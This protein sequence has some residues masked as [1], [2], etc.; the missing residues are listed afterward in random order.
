ME[1]TARQMEAQKAS[2]QA[3]FD[4]VAKRLDFSVKHVLKQAHDAWVASLQPQ[5]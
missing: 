4:D 5:G 2:L 3:A 1:S